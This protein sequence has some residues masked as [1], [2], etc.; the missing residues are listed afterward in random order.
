[1]YIPVSPAETLNY[2]RMR[3]YNE[4]GTTLLADTGQMTANSY[5]SD[6]GRLSFEGHL[7]YLMS[8][9]TVYQLF[10]DIET[11]NGYTDS[12]SYIFTAMAYASGLIN[13]TLD[14]NINEEDGYAQVMLH[15]DGTI[16]HTNVTLRRTSSKSNFTVW[17]D[18]AN[19]TFENSTLDWE[20]DDF[21]I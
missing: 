2:W 14:L 18:I 10:F 6:G 8:S 11:K 9:N 20:F 16:V 5:E 7:K 13:G 21:S 17:E 3:L 4:S 19:K 12:K 1:M 15:G